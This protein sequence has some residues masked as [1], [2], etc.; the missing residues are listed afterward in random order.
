MQ[1][2]R[3]RALIAAGIFSA[4]VALLHVGCLIFGAPWYRFLG[5]GERMARLAERG[6]WYPTLVTS[7]VTLVMIVWSAYAFSGAGVL[8]RLP[9][10]R[11]VIFGAGAILMLR[12]VGAV[13]LVRFFPENSVTFWI[14]TSLA[15]AAGGLLY[16]VGFSQLGTQRAVADSGPRATA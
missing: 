16:L 5:A 1:V 15:S 4:S 6:H 12:G 2:A 9:F 7:V 14:V 3:S 8:R 11:V 13:A 10:L